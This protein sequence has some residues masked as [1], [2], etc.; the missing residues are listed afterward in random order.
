LLLQ[1]EEKVH[2]RLEAAGDGPFLQPNPRSRQVSTIRKL[3]EAIRA[4][5]E[6]PQKSEED[7]VNLLLEIHA[8][9]QGYMDE[10]TEPLPDEVEDSEPSDGEEEENDG[11][12]D[13][14]A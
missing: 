9:R 8:I 7:R 5:E 13:M 11:L 6:I 12:T 10:E 4:F 2:R 3:R 14:N 1:A